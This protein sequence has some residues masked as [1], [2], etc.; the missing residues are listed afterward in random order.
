MLIEMIMNVFET[1]NSNSWMEVVL[2]WYAM[3][4][5]ALDEENC[6]CSPH[7]CVGALCWCLKEYGGNFVY[8]FVIEE[9]AKGEGNRTTTIWHHFVSWDEDDVIDLISFHNVP[10]VLVFRTYFQLM[11][12]RVTMS[13]RNAEGVHDNSFQ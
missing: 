10:L 9:T 11:A 5:V 1:F 2:V 8:S 13:N 3:R 12:S 7:F 4:M 6:L